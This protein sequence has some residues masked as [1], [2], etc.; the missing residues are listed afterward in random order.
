[1]LKETYIIENQKFIRS[2]NNRKKNSQIINKS[3]VFI[4]YRV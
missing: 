2:E 1:M 3:M 4:V